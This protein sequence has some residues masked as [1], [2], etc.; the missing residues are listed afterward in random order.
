MD[1]HH[2]VSAGAVHQPKRPLHGPSMSAH[3]ARKSQVLTIIFV[4]LQGAYGLSAFVSM[5]RQR[6]RRHGWGR[7]RR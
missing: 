2:W 5:W 4:A 3:H 1:L 7:H 6:D